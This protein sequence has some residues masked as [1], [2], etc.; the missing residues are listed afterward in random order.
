MAALDDLKSLVDLLQSVLLPFQ[1]AQAKQS[2][3][4]VL[5][6]QQIQRLVDM[7]Q[8][9]P[10]RQTIIDVMREIVDNQTG[11]IHPALEKIKVAIDEGHRI[12]NQACDSRHALQKERDDTRDV[13]AKKALED[14]IAAIEKV[15]KDEVKPAKDLSEKWDRLKWEVRLVYSAAFCMAGYIIWLWHHLPA[16][17]VI[18]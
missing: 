15:M 11:D 3:A 7:F 2:Q 10:T 17:S 12:R 1:D 4:L 16:A 13:L 8:S 6:T 5:V 9:E 14:I 18:P